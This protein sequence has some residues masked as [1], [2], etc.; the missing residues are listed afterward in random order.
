MYTVPNSLFVGIPSVICFW[1]L[2]RLQGFRDVSVRFIRT[3]LY[4]WTLLH[5]LTITGR[6]CPPFVHYFYLKLVPRGLK[7]T[8]RMYVSWLMPILFDWEARQATAPSGTWDLKHCTWIW[9][10]NRKTWSQ[11]SISWLHKTGVCIWYHYSSLFISSLDSDTC[12]CSRCTAWENLFITLKQ[13][14]ASALVQRFKP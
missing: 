7:T 3:Y 8:C 13:R 12:K 4:M 14:G 9:L 11:R 2:S 10:S 1:F 5:T 6:A